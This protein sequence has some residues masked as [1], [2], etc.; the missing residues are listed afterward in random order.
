MATSKTNPVNADDGWETESDESP[1]Q[2]KFDTFGDVFTGVKCG[3]KELPTNDPADP[4]GLFK[5][6][7]FRS[8][9]MTGLGIDDGELCS[10]TESFKLRELDKIPDGKLIRITYVKDVPMKKGN[11]MRDFKIQSK[12]AS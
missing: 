6:Y 9:G 5:I 12:D 8:V 3:S 11:P 4:D 7:L 2:V 10:V 1:T